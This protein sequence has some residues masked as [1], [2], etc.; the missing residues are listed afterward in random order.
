MQSGLTEAVDEVEKAGRVIAGQRL[1]RIKDAIAVLQQIVRE[2][3]PAEKETE[4]ADSRRG[5]AG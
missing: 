3:E 2:A 4:M 1:D 5:Q